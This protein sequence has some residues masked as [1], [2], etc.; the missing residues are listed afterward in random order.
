MLE[1][2]RI[3]RSGVDIIVKEFEMEKDVGYGIFFFEELNLFD[4][5]DNINVEIKK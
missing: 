3:D 2:L 4:N 1:I 5:V